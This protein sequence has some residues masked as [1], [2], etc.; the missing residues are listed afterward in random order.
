MAKHEARQGSQRG[1]IRAA[2]VAFEQ[3]AVTMEAI[4]VREAGEQTA[5]DAA[6]L[7]AALEEASAAAS[8]VR[9]GASGGLL[10]GPALAECAA[11][12][13]RR[14]DHLAARSGEIADSMTRAA[15]LLIAEDEGVSSRVSRTAG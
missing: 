10:S 12:L 3:A 6:E 9:A 7:V 11:L 13:A 5:A 8:G 4:R 1:P 2:L 15:A 14:A